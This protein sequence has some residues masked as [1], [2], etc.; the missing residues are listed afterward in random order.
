MRRFV[1][2]AS[3]L[4]LTGCGDAPAPPTAAPAADGKALLAAADELERAA[5]VEGALAKA[6]AALAV[7]GGRD[8]AL[9]VAKLAITLGRLDRA[10]A[11]LEPVLAADPND[12]I[13]HY[14]LGLVHHRR[15]DYNRARTSYLAALRA[16]PKHG[17]ARFNLV[18]LCWKKGIAEEAQHHANKF[19]EQFPDD[20]R[21]GQLAAMMT[22]PPTAPSPPAG[23]K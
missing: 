16:N 19:R 2:I 3:V 1:V 12:A 21:V 9:T 13:A 17:E 20:P 15:D 5:D 14:D 7:D 10:Q 18:M 11:V 22:A 6:E 23:P 8:A 4:A